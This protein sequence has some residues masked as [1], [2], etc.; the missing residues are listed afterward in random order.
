MKLI[1]IRWKKGRTSHSLLTPNGGTQATLDARLDVRVVATQDGEFIEGAAPEFVRFEGWHQD[2][3]P[4][5][6]G[7]HTVTLTLSTDDDEV[8]E[9]DGSIT[10]TVLPADPSANAHGTYELNQVGSQESVSLVVAVEDNDRAA[11]TISDATASEDGGSMEFTVT[12][13]D[14]YKETTVDWA[15]SDGSA[16]NAATAGLDYEAASGQLVFNEGETSKTISVNLTDDNLSERGETF[17]VTLSNPTGA[18]LVKASAVGTITDNET[19]AEVT[20]TGQDDSVEEG[21]TASFTI[22]RGPEGGGD[23]PAGFASRPMVIHFTLEQQGEFLRPASERFDGTGAHFDEE[24]GK[25]SVTIPAEQRSFTLSLATI[26]DSLAEL[27]GSV[28]LTLA[29]GALYTVGRPARPR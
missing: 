5:P 28:T 26:D 16:D 23:P 19:L 10:L 6:D 15:T 13:T 9:R 4:D 27:D 7:E 3:H 8:Y 14:T 12:V 18:A 11:M 2:T 1:R 25:S 20:I 22:S 21:G 17:L 24:T 29:G